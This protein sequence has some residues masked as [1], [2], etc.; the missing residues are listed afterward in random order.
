[1]SQNTELNMENFL[2]DK[3]LDSIGLAEKVQNTTEFSNLLE[4]IGLS[5]ENNNKISDDHEECK[6]RS[7][8][9][10]EATNRKLNL[11]QARKSPLSMEQLEL[12]R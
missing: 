3:F 5:D 6:V 1:M 2:F 12:V 9:M 7:N 8:S 11:I 4:R 10:K